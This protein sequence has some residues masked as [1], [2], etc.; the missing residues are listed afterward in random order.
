MP[1]QSGNHGLSKSSV[2][3]IPSRVASA[4]MRSSVYTGTFRLI[5][6]A[7]IVYTPYLELWLNVRLWLRLLAIL[8]YN[9]GLDAELA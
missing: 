8:R 6:F 9:N 1:P 3:L 2:R 5:S 4:S 7:L